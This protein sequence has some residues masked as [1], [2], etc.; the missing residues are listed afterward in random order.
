MELAVESDGAA[1]GVG[2]GGGVEATLELRVVG[3]GALDGGD[4]CGG[5]EGYADLVGGDG[6]DVGLAVIAPVDFD[7]VWRRFD[8]EVLAEAYALGAVGDAIERC[9][10]SDAGLV[11]VGSDD[12]AGLDG[13]A[14]GA[15]YAALAGSSLLRLNFLDFLD[16][17]LPV[18]MHAEGGGAIEEE[19]MEE[20]SAQASTCGCGE[21]CLGADRGAGAIGVEETDS[22]EG[23][24]FDGGEVDSE[25]GEGGYGVRH[26]ALAAGFVDGGLHAVGD[27]YG[28]TALCSSDGTGEA[29]G[30]SSGDEDVGASCFL[31]IRRVENLIRVHWRS[32][33]KDFAEELF[34][35]HFSKTSSE[36]K[37]G[38]MAARML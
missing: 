22:A 35:Y 27:F 33:K 13:V 21:G 9:A 14:V 16:Y 10:G 3:E 32:S 7:E 12:E 38:P 1:R 8:L 5:Y 19:L 29:G 36:Q 20:G 17:G 31:R 30:T 25:I 2:G 26:E 37:A 15:D 18:E 28:E 6:G 24:A 11:A 4:F 34:L 23:G